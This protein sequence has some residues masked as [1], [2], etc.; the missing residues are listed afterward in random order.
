MGVMILL[1]ASIQEGDIGMFS[2]S[3]GFLC[4][5][6]PG[7]AAA[8]LA[9]FAFHLELDAVGRDSARVLHGHLVSVKLTDHLERYGIAVDLSVRDLGLAAAPGN[10]ASESAAIGLQVDRPCHGAVAALHFI[11]PFARGVSGQRRNRQGTG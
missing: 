6:L 2:L 1:P 9:A 11:G 7:A 10:G 3:A 4:D 8:A 5:E